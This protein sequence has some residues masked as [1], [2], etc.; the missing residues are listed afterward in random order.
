MFSQ[1][2]SSTSL[3]ITMRAP[4]SLCAVLFSVLPAA[5][6][7]VLFAALPAVLLAV[8]LALLLAVLLAMVLMYIEIY[9]ASVTKYIT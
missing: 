2:I 4:K 6:L 8:P 7:A 5:L 9:A 3:I 1:L